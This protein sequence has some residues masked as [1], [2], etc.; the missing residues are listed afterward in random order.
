MRELPRIYA[1]TAG[2]GVTR[3]LAPQIAEIL[4]AG[5]LVQLRE[6]WSTARELFHLL[7]KVVAGVP[8]SRL[9]NLLVNDRL[10]LALSFP[11]IGVH[12][13]ESGLPMAIARRLLGPN[14]LLGASCH[15]AKGLQKARN[16][17]AN[18]ATISP[19]F[20][21]PGKGQPMGIMAL[22]KL[23]VPKGLKLFALGGIDLGNAAEMHLPGI[24]GVAAIRAIFSHPN[25]CTGAEELRR[26]LL[27]PGCQ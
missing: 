10:D 22:G 25:P 13:P 5:H 6:K 14:R 26:R 12:L 21:T 9:S 8:S 27:A 16:E 4:A 17:G 18:L 3:I 19:I 20:A 15:N 24:H 23:P 2:T 1:I 7:E 11:Q